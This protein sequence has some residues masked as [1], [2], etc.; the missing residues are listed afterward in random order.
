MNRLLFLICLFSI[1]CSRIPQPFDNGTP[2]PYYIDPYFNDMLTQFKEDAA[3]HG[4][5][6]GAIDTLTVI[7]FSS[8][9]NDIPLSATGDCKYIREESYFYHNF[10]KEV[11]F[12]PVFKTLDSQTQYKL[13]LHEMGHCVFA[14]KDEFEDQD[15]IMF[16]ALGYYPIPDQ[17]T[18]EMMAEIE[19]L[20]ADLKKTTWRPQECWMGGEGGDC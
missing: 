3:A 6:P 11:N 4:V 1:A 16:Y 14:L 5:E 15:A 13:F 12:K 20:R 8:D 9:P 7:K 18:P 19:A 10:H 17:A 2:I